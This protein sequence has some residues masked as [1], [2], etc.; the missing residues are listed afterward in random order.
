MCALGLNGDIFGKEDSLFG[1][2]SYEGDLEK[3]L[4]FGLQCQFLI[5]LPPI[6]LDFL[7]CY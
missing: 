5:Y 2:L 4:L 1:L 7:P 6:K 3:H